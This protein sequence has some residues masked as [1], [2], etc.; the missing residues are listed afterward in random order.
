MRPVPRTRL[1]LATSGAVA[2]LGAVLGVALLVAGTVQVVRQDQIAGL[3]RPVADYPIAAHRAGQLL[4]GHAQPDPVGRAVARQPGTPGGSG[5]TAPAGPVHQLPNTIRL[6]HGGTADLVP[7][8]VGADGSL[9]IPAGVDQATWWGV[10]IDA[11]GGA[12]VFAGHVNWAGR[13]GP[14]AELWHD[15]VGD[16]VSVAD[17]GGRLWLFRVSQVLTLTKDDLPRQAPSL[18]SPSGPHRVVLATCGGE[19]IGGQLGYAD[20]RVLI[21]LPQ[22]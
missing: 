17:T 14:F 10:A 21:A 12:S 20:N 19:W 2:V 5:G 4:A 22:G 13:I 7:G 8:K 3:P 15:Q 16:L 1:A 6:P 11:P 18:F 9:P